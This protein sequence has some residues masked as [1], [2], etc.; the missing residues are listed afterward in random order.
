MSSP[1][2]E[3]SETE[4]VRSQQNPNKFVVPH[5]SVTSNKILVGAMFVIGIAYVVYTLIATLGRTAD[6]TNKK[7][8]LIFAILY[9]VLSILF[10]LVA[11]PLFWIIHMIY[12]LYQSS[13]LSI[14]NTGFIAPL[15]SKFR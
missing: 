3:T 8:I 14:V 4:T 9:A 11:S 13:K 7:E 6:M 10:L 2:Q 1:S 5:G 15:I 12:F